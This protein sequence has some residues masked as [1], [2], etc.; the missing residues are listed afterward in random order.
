VGFTGFLVILIIVLLRSR[1]I[2]PLSSFLT[3]SCVDF[4]FL[5][6]VVS[7]PFS[8]YCSTWCCVTMFL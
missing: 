4:F 3:D 1:T 7:I 5:R 6:R 2:Y 8:S